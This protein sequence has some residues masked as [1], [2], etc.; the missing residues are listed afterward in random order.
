[1]Y[2]PQVTNPTFEQI[3]AQH[4]ENLF[5][6]IPSVRT[7]GIHHF[8]VGLGQQNLNLIIRLPSD[9][10]TSPPILSLSRL[11]VHPMI[12]QGSTQFNLDTSA[13]E[14]WHFATSQLGTWVAE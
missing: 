11:V 12:K 13:I 5:K 8:E 3:K 4:I 7:K 6:S 2:P 1:M 10:P 9:F 14:P